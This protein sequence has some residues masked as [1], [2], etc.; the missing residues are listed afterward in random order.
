MTEEVATAIWFCAV[1]LAIETYDENDSVCLAKITAC[2]ALL[3]LG[4]EYTPNAIEKCEDVIKE[5]KAHLTIS[6]WEQE[7]AQ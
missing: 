4:I 3:E 2:E 7:R 5:C 1:A 6:E